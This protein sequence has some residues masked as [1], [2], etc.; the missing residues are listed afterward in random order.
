MIIE[1]AQELGIALSE[2]IEFQ[3]MLAAKAKV[4]A[5]AGIS[6]MMREYTELRDSIVTLMEDA[7]ADKGTMLDI[8]R[9]MDEIQAALMGNAAFTELLAAQQCFQNLMRQVNQT[10]AACIGME[11]PDMDTPEGGCSAGSCASCSG[12]KH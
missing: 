9:Q 10:I 8:G 12:C 2:S 1:K 4:D 6:N 3:G 5:N 11:D 7:E